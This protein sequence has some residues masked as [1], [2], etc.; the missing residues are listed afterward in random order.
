MRIAILADI[1]ANFQALQAVFA[2]IKKMEVDEVI[3]LGDNIGYGP[4]P[5]EVVRE[6]IKRNVYSI[7]GNHEL[8]LTSKSY[9]EQ[10]NFITKDSLELTKSL[11]SRDTIT[12]STELDSFAIR[13]GARFVHGTPPESVVEYLHELSKE[14]QK[15]LFTTFPEQLCFS[16]HTHTLETLVQ[17]RS[18]KSIELQKLT[19]GIF[20]FSNTRRYIFNPGSVGQPRDGLNRK[21]KYCI[22]SPRKHSCIIREIEYDSQKTVNLLQKLDFPVTNAKR[23]L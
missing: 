7:I 8:A 17:D 3:S 14:Q 22:W 18:D 12:W 6:L 16:G 5:E 11:M 2:D 10:L 23:L 21:S 13:H 15:K 4:Q 1:H 20:H 19:P 9:Y